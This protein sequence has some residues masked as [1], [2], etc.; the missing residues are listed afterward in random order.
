[1]TSCIT[2]SLSYLVL[3][4]LSHRLSSDGNPFHQQHDAAATLMRLQQHPSTTQP[5]S[6]LAPGSHDHIPSNTMYNVAS[7]PNPLLGPSGN[8]KPADM[9]GSSIPSILPM[10]PMA[11]GNAPAFGQDQ[12]LATGI[13]PAD[14]VM[15][16]NMPWGPF[17]QPLPPCISPASTTTGP[18]QYGSETMLAQ[19]SGLGLAA[20]SN[21]DISSNVAF[22]GLDNGAAGDDGRDASSGS[23][24]AGPSPAQGS[25]KKTSRQSRANSKSNTCPQCGKSYARQSTLK[26]HMRTHTGERPYQCTTCDKSFSQAANLNAHLRTHTGDKPFACTICQRRFSQSSSVTTH[27]RTHSGERPYHCQLCNKSFADTSTLTK[28]IRTHTGRKPYACRVCGTSFSQSGNLNRHMR[29]HGTAARPS[30]V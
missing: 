4:C 30:D 14:G 12:P 9:L 23:G 3:L 20:S 10:P 7:L 15:G 25:P 13:M 5:N 29:T 21:D 8:T 16:G 6:R 27:M 2:L 24:T 19:P 11:L 18:M 28:H 26:T 1:M 17:H 22:A